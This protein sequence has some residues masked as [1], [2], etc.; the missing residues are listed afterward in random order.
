MK[1]VVLRYGK[2]TATH[3]PQVSTM[4]HVLTPHLNKQYH[5]W[6]KHEPSPPSDEINSGCV[7]VK[8][9]VHPSCMQKG[10]G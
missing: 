5:T 7:F 9:F 1:A 2:Q 10:F 6:N 4:S 8:V 3:T